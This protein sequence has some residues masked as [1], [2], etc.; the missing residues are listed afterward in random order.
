M[1][2]IFIT[3]AFLAKHSL[4][5]YLR[6]WGENANRPVH[7]QVTGLPWASSDFVWNDRPMFTDIPLTIELPAT[8]F[9]ENQSNDFDF[10]DRT[11]KGAVYEA[12]EFSCLG[13]A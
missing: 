4:M 13:G 8:V 12:S 3:G 5:H 10:I 1:S 7:I 2:N 11:V 9:G 6:M